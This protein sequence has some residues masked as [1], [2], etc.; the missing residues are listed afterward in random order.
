MAARNTKN[1]GI[2]TNLGVDKCGFI[3][4]ERRRDLVSRD[5]KECNSTVEK[6]IFDGSFW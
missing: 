6:A 3:I 4:P 5:G 2:V 1:H